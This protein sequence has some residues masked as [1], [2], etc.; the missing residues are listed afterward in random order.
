MTLIFNINCNVSIANPSPPPKKNGIES[1]S[2]RWKEKK[3]ANKNILINVSSYR[4][5][6]VVRFLSQ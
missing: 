6:L 1:G 3:I 4:D 2:M 5:W